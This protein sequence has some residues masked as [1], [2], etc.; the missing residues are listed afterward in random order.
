[1]G[2]IILEDGVVSFAIFVSSREGNDFVLSVNQEGQC[3]LYILN[4]VSMKE[5]RCR[6]RTEQSE[7]MQNT[8][9]SFV[10]VRTWHHATG[11]PPIGL[12]QERE[13]LQPSGE[14]NRSSGPTTR[15]VRL[16][17]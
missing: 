5:A 4:A 1:M 2:R 12:K 13:V 14:T 15:I 3:R 8:N 9:V 7:V 17:Q 11:V 10:V 16:H 6:T